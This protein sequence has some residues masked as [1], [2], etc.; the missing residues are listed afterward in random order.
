MEENR[1]EIL[2]IF[3]EQR[4]YMERRIAEGI[5]SNRKGNLQVL[6]KGKDGCPVQKANVRIRQMTH[7][8]LYGANLFMLDEFETEEKNLLYRKYFSEI[9]NQATLPFYWKDLEPVQGKPRYEINA[10][11][12]YRRPAP[13]YCLKYCSENQIVPKAHCLYYEPFMPTWVPDEKETTEEYLIGHFQELAARYAGKIHGW[14]VINET[15]TREYGCAAT[16]FYDEPELIEWCFQEAEKYFPDNE[17][18]INEAHPFIW[19]QFKGTRSA[20]YLLIER[21]LQKGARIDTIGLQ[22]HMF[23]DVNRY[24]DISKTYYSP[25]RIFDVLDC[26]AN[27]GKPI[28]I[29]EITIPAYSATEE[30]EMIQC[31]VLRNVYRMWFSHSAVEAITY[32]NLVDGYAAYAELGD[33]TSGENIYYGGLMRHD[34]TPKPAYFAIKDMFQKEF[35]TECEQITDEMGNFAFRGFYGEYDLE[36]EKDGKKLHKHIH[37]SKGC[38]NSIIVE[39]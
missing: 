38:E 24:V 5:E 13:D 30:D 28:Q 23:H 22:Y 20:Y 17:L 12:V 10:P 16:R 26:Y 1:K 37:L 32:W 39:E 31:E 7:D 25:K 21:A 11:K 34:L 18:I 4:E 27:F 3:E 14:E 33:M 29:T 9:F 2:Q 8:F 36:I 35:H 19:E 15:L 6:L